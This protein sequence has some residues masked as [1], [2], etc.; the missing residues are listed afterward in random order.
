VHNYKI[1]LIR[2]FWWVF[3]IRSTSD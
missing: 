3:I 1:Q 2:I